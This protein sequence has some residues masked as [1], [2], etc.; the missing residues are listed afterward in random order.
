VDEK[1]TVR[2]TQNYMEQSFLCDK[3]TQR[4][5][6]PFKAFKRI[7][8]PAKVNKLSEKNFTPEMLEETTWDT[9]VHT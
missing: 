6:M 1:P 8:G 5:C 2:V 4:S 7:D 9:R 3:G